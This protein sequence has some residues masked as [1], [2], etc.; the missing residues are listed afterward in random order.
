MSA[1][2]QS[3]RMLPLSMFFLPNACRL[4]SGKLG[5]LVKKARATFTTVPEVKCRTRVI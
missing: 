4:R 3:T 5:W 2:C 1:V